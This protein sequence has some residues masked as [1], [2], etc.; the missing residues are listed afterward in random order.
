MSVAFIRTF[1]GS[2]GIYRASRARL[3]P[4]IRVGKRVFPPGVSLTL[5]L[6]MMSRA[7]KVTARIGSCPAKVDS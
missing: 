1:C 2:L 4:S 6:A 3:F 5:F 7:G